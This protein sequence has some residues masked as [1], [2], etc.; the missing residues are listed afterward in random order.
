MS[1]LGL[2]IGLAEWPYQVISELGFWLQRHL[3][4]LAGLGAAGPGWIQRHGVLVVFSTTAALLTLGWGPLAAGR[5]G[6]IAP[7]IALDR[8]SDPLQ[9]EREQQW[10][11]KL[12]LRT[13]LIRLPLVLLSHLGGLSVGVESPSASLGASVLLAIRRRWPL[14]APL[15][16]MPLPLVGVIGGAAGLGAAFRSPL[17]GV[18]YGLEELGRRCGLPLVL[19]ALVLGAIGGLVNTGLGQ[20]ARLP[21]LQL[22][23][24]EAVL[25][26]WAVLI[27]AL[28]ALLGAAFVRL[29]IVVSALVQRGFGRWRPGLILILASQ[30]SLLAWLS[31][32]LSLNDGSLSLAAALQGSAG[33]PPLTLLWRWLSSLVSIAAGAPGGLMHDVMTLGALLPGALD[34]LPPLAALAAPAHAQ[35]AAVGA[36]ALFAAAN[37]TPIFCALFVFTLQG[38]P[39]LLL[40]L[41]LVSAVSE[42]LAAPLRQVGWNEHLS[43]ALMR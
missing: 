6:G 30:L 23:A 37:G 2:L 20:P 43:Q 12:S 24:L 26:P 17:L 25:W 5:S 21:G 38:D 27:T 11:A 35:L 14:W 15:A 42:A 33:G 8:S 1:A 29:L 32:G 36:T 39:Q 18:V 40:V 10:L 9:P 34:W 7:L 22:G 16:A 28:G 41:L 19:P 31:G 3:W 13:Q 4:P